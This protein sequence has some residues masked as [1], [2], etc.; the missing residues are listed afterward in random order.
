MVINSTSPPP[1]LR[2]LNAIEIVE[3]N[4]GKSGFSFIIK[5]HYLSKARFFLNQKNREYPSISTSLL[6][7]A[8]LIL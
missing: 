6:F 4:D 7:H 1:P 3:S 5:V 2:N 8:E